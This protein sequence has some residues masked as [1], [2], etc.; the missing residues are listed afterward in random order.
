M[1]NLS[2]SL[3]FFFILA[4]SITCSAI[5]HADRG[6]VPEVWTAAAAVA[7]ALDS[8]PDVVVARKRI[9]TAQTA[10]RLAASANYPTV[11]ISGEYGQTTT[12]MY[13]FGNILNQGAFDNS[14]DFNDPGRTD[15][16]QL[17]A[18]LSHTFYNGGRNQAEEE[19]AAAAALVTENDLTVVHHQLGYETVKAFHAIAQSEKMVTVREQEL[20]AISS[21]LAV[22]SARYEAG[23]LLRQ[24]LLNLEL[25]Q[26]RASENLIH[27]RHQLELGKRTFLNLLGLPPRAVNVDVGRDSQQQLPTQI[28][29]HDRPELKRLTAMITT[30]EAELRAAEAGKRPT[31]DAYAAYQIDSGLIEEESGDS[32]QAGVRLNHILFDG[33][34]TKNRIA[35]ARLKIQELQGSKRKAEMAFDLELQQAEL[36]YRQT[37]ERLGVTAKMVDVAEEVTRLSR[38]RFREGVILASEMIELEMRLT[39]AHARQLSAVAAHQVAIANLRRTAGLPQ[40]PDSTL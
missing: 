13:S 38:A 22:G 2:L 12:P 40:F 10:T 7:Y 26:A 20:N 27:S 8:N 33:E 14:I 37:E 1:K 4:L 11:G 28:D 30:A 21:A 18:S 15:N 36:D 16:L 9:E 23:D 19:A 25:Q 35:M 31:V 3:P 34:R 29:Y 5:A 32:W 17:R 39:D 24:D 6:E